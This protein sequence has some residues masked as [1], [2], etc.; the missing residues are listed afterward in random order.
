MQAITYKQLPQTFLTLGINFMKDNFS[1]DW[2]VRRDGFR[3]IQ[4]YC[5][6]GA[7]DFSGGSLRAQL[8]KNLP[9]IQET[10]VQFLGQGDPLE[11]G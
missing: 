6:Y 11:K 2:C 7:L 1:T 3:M 10:H 4:A 9:A 8:V 5:I